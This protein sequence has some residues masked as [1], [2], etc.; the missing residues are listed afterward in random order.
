[1]RLREADCRRGRTRFEGGR[2]RRD[3]SPATESVRSTRRG[4]TTMRMSDDP[5]LRDYDDY[6]IGSILRGEGT[7]FFL[8]QGIL[9]AAYD[10]LG[11]DALDEEVSRT[12][13]IDHWLGSDFDGVIMFGEGD[14]VQHAAGE[15]SE[16]CAH[17]NLNAVPQA[18]SVASKAAA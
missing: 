15:E 18:A 16:R 8:D 3:G 7:A 11:H 6:Y 1:M 9:F 5:A 14:A 4:D 12:R 13:Q 2:Y 10:A 17:D